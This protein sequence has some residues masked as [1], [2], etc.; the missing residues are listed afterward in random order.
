MRLGHPNRLVIR[1][2]LLAIAGAQQ[3]Q[4]LRLPS[5]LLPRSV[6]ILASPVAATRPYSRPIH[7]VTRSAVASCVTCK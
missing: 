7:A 4:S 2:S 3:K 5:N 1:P 6:P